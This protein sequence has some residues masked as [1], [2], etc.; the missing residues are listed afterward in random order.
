ML[1]AQL[2]Q[3]G[4]VLDRGVHVLGAAG[5]NGQLQYATSTVS[6]SGFI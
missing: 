6:G 5:N 1:S 3:L 4:L 2:R